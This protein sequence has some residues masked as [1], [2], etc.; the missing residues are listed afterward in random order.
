MRPALAIIGVALGLAAAW[1][2]GVGHATQVCPAKYQ[3][4]RNSTLTCTANCERQCASK[5]ER[6]FRSHPEKLKDSP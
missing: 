4:V 6:V 5:L 2:M 3:M 1:T